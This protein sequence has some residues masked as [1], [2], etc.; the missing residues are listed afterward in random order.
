M[1]KQ[2][3][4]RNATVDVLRFVCAIGIVLH[5][6]IGAFLPEN[7]L[8]LTVNAYTFVYSVN[9][10]FIISGYAITESLKGYVATP[11]NA[12]SYV[13]RRSL[14]LDLP[15]WIMLTVYFCIESFLNQRN[16]GLTDLVVNSIYGQ[17]I[18][19]YKPIIGIAWTLCIEV[20]F[21]TLMLA[22]TSFQ[23]SIKRQYVIFSVLIIGSIIIKFTTRFL[24][25][26]TYVF[27]YLPWFLV[28]ILSSYQRSEKISTTIPVIVG[29]L[30][31][32][33]V[34]DKLDLIDIACTI[35]Y[36]LVTHVLIV[37]DKTESTSIG[38][39]QFSKLGSYTYSIY[40]THMLSIKA[41]QQ[42]SVLP[43]GTLKVIGAFILTA[44]MSIILNKFI[45]QPALKLSR[46]ISYRN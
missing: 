46:K 31:I 23:K 34:L 39:Q 15:Y 18:F 42:F 11:K 37:K 45:E 44:V 33:C 35:F 24:S 10:F 41:I 4:N 27:Q 43:G 7:S 16:Y 13:I 36:G 26:D 1:Y 28:G 6:S 12:L 20:Q 17:R 3:S 30:A 29:V 32:R 40:L 21:Y 19:G 14:R 22:V 9:I 2:S 38:I 5:H 25:D 8:L